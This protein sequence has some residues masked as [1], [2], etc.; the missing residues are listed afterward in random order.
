MYDWAN[1]V[2]SLVI[3]SSLFPIY[4]KSVAVA[5]GSDVITFFTFE[6]KN[7]ILYSYA[8]SLSFLLVALMLP[9]LSGIADYTGNKKFFM[10]VF[11]YV[12][13]FACMGLYFFSN[14]SFVPWAL[15]LAMLAS[16]GYSGSLV[17]YDAFLPEIVTRDRYDAISAR[18]YA[19]GYLG[20]VILLILA[21]AGITYAD[22]LGTTSGFVTRL[23]FLATGFWW[24]GFSFIPF[25]VLKEHSPVNNVKNTLWNG[26]IE[27]K[28]VWKEVQASKALENYLFAFFFFNMGVQSVMYLAQFFG[29][30][31]LHMAES[32][33]IAIILIIQFIG[34]IGALLFARLSKRL[35]NK[36]T[37]LILI[38]IW[39]GICVF[40]YTITLETE[41]FALAFVVGAVMGGIQALSR[42][43]YSKLLPPTTHDHASYFSF[44]DVTFN[45]SIVMGTFSYGFIN[46]LTGSMRYSVLGLAVYFIIGLIFLFQVRSG[47]LHAPGSPSTSNAS[48]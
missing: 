35:G 14:V 32:K 43:T 31:V 37:L 6:L 45:I 17:F 27:I 25:S 2:Y 3:S 21:L 11:V 18:G 34:L 13:S 48:R 46:H 23:S 1:S 38:S 40:A 5:D 41:F 9:L 29:T 44:Y 24:F 26:Y 33:L 10:K 8:L 20:G 30:E 42:A 39:I 36:N 7:S 19:F 16:I 4:F 15:A 28:K 12:G 22:A 47:S